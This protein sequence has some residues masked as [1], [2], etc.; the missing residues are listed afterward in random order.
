M[1]WFC[2][3]GDVLVKRGCQ[4]IRNGYALISIDIYQNRPSHNNS[5]IA[6]ILM[7][8]QSSVRVYL[9]FLSMYDNQNQIYNKRIKGNLSVML[10]K[11]WSPTEFVRAVAKLSKR[12]RRSLPGF[13][14]LVRDIS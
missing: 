2:R 6:N 13:K 14:L 10:A 12:L 8:Y 3:K 9:L 7:R 11:T 5:P 1:A 4:L